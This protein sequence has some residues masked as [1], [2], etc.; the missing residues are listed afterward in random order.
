LLNRSEFREFARQVGGK[1][2]ANMTEFGKTPFIT[3]SEFRRM[4]YTF[5]IFPV[6]LF[7]GAA[8][9]QQLCLRELLRKGTQ[10]GLM[11]KLMSREEQYKVIRYAEYVNIDKELSFGMPP[12]SRKRGKLEQH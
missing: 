11:P 4:G 6:T 3:A 1:L 10:K 2:L 9:V 7:R 12:S 8:R 5:V